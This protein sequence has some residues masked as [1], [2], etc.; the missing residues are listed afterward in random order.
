MTVPLLI[1]IL[2]GHVGNGLTALFGGFAYLYVWNEPYGERARRV[3]LVALGIA[4]AYVAGAFGS[5]FGV[6]WGA[7]LAIAL[8]SIGAFILCEVLAVKAPASFFFIFACATGTGFVGS[9][10]QIWWQGLWAFLGGAFAWV[11]AMLPWLWNPHGPERAAVQRV[12][13]SLASLLGA[14]GTSNLGTAQHQATLALRAAERALPPGETRWRRPGDY[15]RL[16]QMTIHAEA[17]FLVIIDLSAKHNEPVAPRLPAFLRALADSV[18]DPERAA[19]L[20]LPQIDSPSP[21]LI[22]RLRQ[23]ATIA[24]DV[25]P[26]PV[27]EAERQEES[28]SSA[29]AGALDRRSPTLFRALR[30]GLVVLLAH[31]I[32]IWIGAPNAKWVPVSAMA[33]MV[34]LTTRMTMRRTVQ[35]IVGTVIG[36]GIGSLL[37]SLHP[38]GIWIVAIILPL[39]FLT[40]SSILINYGYAMLF[41]TPLSFLMA[42]AGRPDLSV[43][44]LAT[45]R[46]GDIILGSLLGLAGTLIL[47]RRTTVRQLQAVLAETI[48]QVGGLAAGI[49][50]TT[51]LER[52]RVRHG[53]A[54]LRLVY[55][56]ALAEFADVEHLWPAVAAVQRTGYLL[57]A[58][59]DRAKRTQVESLEPLSDQLRS[60][61][62]AL[63]TGGAP[64][65]VPEAVK[66]AYPAVR[67]AVEA[68]GE[69]LR[70]LPAGARV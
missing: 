37:L 8:V 31:V 61:A 17:V 10:T 24:V 59:S 66:M 54:T 60:W 50:A 41:A 9:P 51:P 36:A 11:V 20:V 34:G 70:F 65:A 4:L 28:L 63:E 64:T 44:Y 46:V 23:A 47:Q 19:C 29:L 48:R 22:E 33:V 62:D 67:E 25:D 7:G 32:A 49:T 27:R 26:A 42:E 30:L 53:L 6:L 38:Q 21:M 55:D 16:T 52:S 15:R 43:Q 40:E 57:L 18:M 3:A 39:Q 2:T 56:D 69:G 58:L 5:F 68:L 45:A 1:G 35:R 12:Y 14:V 13:Q